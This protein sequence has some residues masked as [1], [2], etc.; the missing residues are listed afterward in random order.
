[1]NVHYRL[2]VALGLAAL[3]LV[4]RGGLMTQNSPPQEHPVFSNFPGPTWDGDKEHGK[5]SWPGAGRWSEEDGWPGWQHRPDHTGRIVIDP[6]HLPREWGHGHHDN[7]DW[8]SH[9]S[10]GHNH[11]GWRDPVTDRD[12]GQNG[13][14]A[15]PDGGST[16]ALLGGTLSA[17]LGG[18]AW[19]SRRPN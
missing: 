8:D 7:D 18:R 11:D 1:M 5:S 4:S 10:R 3:P 14:V 16:A 2:L 12:G 15:V 13:S 19:R 9:D 17:L 6:D